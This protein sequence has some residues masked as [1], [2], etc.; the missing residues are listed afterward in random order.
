MP[1]VS[2]SIAY[3]RSN[4]GLRA[5]LAVFM[6]AVIGVATLGLPVVFGGA[7]TTA[8]AT[9]PSPE[10][11]SYDSVTQAESE[12]GP[13]DDIYLGDNESAVLHYEDDSDVDKLDMGMD[14]SEGL[15]HMLVV[16]D[17]DDPDEELESANFSAMLDQQGLSGS[18]S[19]VMERPDDLESFDAD[20]SGEVSE[21]T[22]E[23]DAS[24]SGTFDSQ[25]TS[26]GTG[27]TSGEVSVTADRFETSGDVTAEMDSAGSGSDMYVDAS[28]TE[29]SNGYT[30]DVTQEQT[31]TQWTASQWETREQARQTLQEQYGTLATSL[32]GTS[33]IEITNYDFQEGADGQS[34]V[35]ISYSVTYT[36]IDDG[37]EQQLTDQLTAD[38]STDLTRSEAREIAASVTDVELEQIE[39]MLDV[40]DNSM[41]AEWDVAIANYDELTFAMFDLMEATDTTGQ[42]PEEQLENARAAIEAQQAAN[43]ESTVSWDGSAE[44]SSDE[45]TFDATV[46]GDTKNW[47]AYIDELESRDMD[48]PH[49]VT[50][51]LT[52]DTDG[53]EL[54]MDG[55]FELEAEDLAGQAINSW[56]ESIQSSESS[57]MSPET[58]EFVS[59][60]DE[61]ELEVARIDAG[62]EDGTVRVEAGARFEDMSKITDTLTDSMSISGVATEQHDETASMYVYVDDMDGIDTASAT[63]ADLEHLDVVGTETTVHEAGEW[64]DDL[65]QADTDAMSEFLETEDAENTS[66]DGNDDEDSDSVPGFGIGAALASLAAL[67]TALVLGRR[68]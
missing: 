6:V 38:R 42:L 64:D 18:G 8:E 66:E 1:S 50:F 60:L 20:V 14:V 48:A 29:T 23:F 19:M 27:S 4:D 59:A 62:L 32:G 30:V 10:M 47:D 53:D 16:D 33:E 22:N 55:K 5:F 36:G 7:T 3:L 49:D 67:L 15:V 2:K 65:P 56:A 35:D 37:I 43:L 45:I 21:D 13:A 9:E 26:A 61:S 68:A 52:A 46:T 41:D 31:L 12:L 11:E 51:E 25:S 63:K 57:T 17:I 58:E 28:L 54:S 40:S 39:F 44:Q 34:Q 24:T